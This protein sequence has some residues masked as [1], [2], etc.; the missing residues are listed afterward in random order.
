M[1]AEVDLDSYAYCLRAGS[2]HNEL[3][4]AHGAGTLLPWY[5]RSR[6]AGATHVEVLEAHGARDD[7]HSYIYCREAGASHT[8]V[9]EA[10]GAGAA[11][12]WYVY[13]RNAGATHAEVLETIGAKADLYRYAKCR[14]TGATH[15]EG[16]ALRLNEL[17]A[18]R[19]PELAVHALRAA[20]GTNPTK[21]LAET[22]ATLA[23][24]W[25]GTADELA[26]TAIALLAPRPN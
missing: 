23:Q 1:G 6:K 4:M 21:E 22:I 18:H 7:L 12:H 26:A 17:P 5:I 11:L 19:N 2:H 14:K 9:L 24:D 25:A 8:E 13:C 15:A 16:Q 3:L 10:I 20:C